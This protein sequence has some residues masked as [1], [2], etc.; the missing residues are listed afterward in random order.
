[1]EGKVEAFILLLPFPCFSTG[2]QAESS[3][4]PHRGGSLRKGPERPANCKIPDMG[5]LSS[6]H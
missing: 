5:K 4:A 3:Q 2:S 6:E 1:M